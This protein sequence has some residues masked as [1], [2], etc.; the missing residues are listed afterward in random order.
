MHQPSQAV[1]E[2]L[3]AIA[4]QSESSS[5]GETLKSATVG[6]IQPKGLGSAFTQALQYFSGKLFAGDMVAKFDG[7]NASEASLFLKF[8]L[9]EVSIALPEDGITNIKRDASDRTRPI[10]WHLDPIK[11]ADFL[12]AFEKLTAEIN[13]GDLAKDLPTISDAIGRAHPS[14]LKGLSVEL[15]LEDV[16][17]FLRGEKP[18]LGAI[19]VVR[20]SVEN[21]EKLLKG[22]SITQISD[23]EARPERM[24]QDAW[25]TWKD[26]CPRETE[27]FEIAPNHPDWDKVIDNIKALVVEYRRDAQKKPGP[28]N[29]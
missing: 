18:A 22:T 16:T 20:M 29:R 24:T 13:R 27:K 11:A 5:F 17:E 4:T 14:R 2:F 25:V 23:I 15:L 6:S 3:T 9:E 8:M 26:L 19:M 12:K 21:K 10:S 1:K 28:R 7:M